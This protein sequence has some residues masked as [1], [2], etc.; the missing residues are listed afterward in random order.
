MLQLESG[1]FSA[2]ERRATGIL[3]LSADTGG[4]KCEVNF[5]P[6]T[7]FLLRKLGKETHKSRG[8]ASANCGQFFPVKNFRRSSW[9]APLQRARRP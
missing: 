7:C 1:Q 9:A 8:D 2:E 5:R 4:G 6:E 3:E